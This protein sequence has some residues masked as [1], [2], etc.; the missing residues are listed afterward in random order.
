[1]EM[2][3]YLSIILSEQVNLSPSACGGLIRLAVK[4]EIG[5]YKPTNQLNLEDYKKSCENAL[6]HRLEKL[7][8]DNID[9]IITRIVNEL[10]QNQSLITMETV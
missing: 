5:P 9:Q 7:G 3:K 6:K 2:I 4:D 8:V 1:M 10:I